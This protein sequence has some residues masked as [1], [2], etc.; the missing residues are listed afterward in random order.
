MGEEARESMTLRV[1]KGRVEGV[2]ESIVR[3]GVVAR[4]AFRE[5]RGRRPV[6]STLTTSPPS[7]LRGLA[8]PPAAEGGLGGYNWPTPPPQV[9]LLTEVIFGGK[10]LATPSNHPVAMPLTDT[11]RLRPGPNTCGGRVH[12]RAWLV[13]GGGR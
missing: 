6:P 8:T 7:K 9:S 3:K 11:R 10:S 4:E 13:W 2:E 12:T 5:E 1:G